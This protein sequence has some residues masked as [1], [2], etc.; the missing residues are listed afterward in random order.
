[1][2]AALVTTLVVLLVS[3]SFP[4]YCYAAYIMIEADPVGW[5][6]VKRHAIYTTAGLTLN[7]IPVIFWMIPQ[8]AKQFGGLSTLHAFL[9][10]QAYAF[11]VLAL[12]GVWKIYRAKRAYDQYHNPV[13]DVAL[14]ELDPE[15]MSGWRTQL[16]LGVVGWM[17][18]W[19][20]AY[21]TGLFLY[22]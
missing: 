20:L 9:G 21:V 16:R 11:L 12:N 15:R 17:G 22:V 6:D 8:L 3:A 10:L 18:F 7:T 1:M 4:F 19:L 13:E 14:T 2:A 5:A